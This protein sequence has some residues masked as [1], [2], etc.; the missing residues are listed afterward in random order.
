M[1]EKETK[2]YTETAT[3]QL[4]FETKR[5]IHFEHVLPRNYQN[6]TLSGTISLVSQKSAQPEVAVIDK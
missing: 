4:D 3:A 5:H 2:K 1:G 6:A